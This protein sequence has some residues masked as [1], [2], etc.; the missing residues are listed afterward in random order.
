MKRLISVILTLLMFVSC[1][2]IAEGTDF[3]A[4]DDATL[5]A[6]IN[7]ARNE[8]TKREMVAAEN[9]VLFEQDGVSVY[10]TGKHE[11]W[12]SDSYYLDLEAVLVNDS[13][14]S[15]YL[16][17]DTAYVNGWEVY[18]GG[19][20]D[21]AAGKKQKANID[22]SISEAGITTYE[23]IEEIEVNIWL[24]DSESYEAIAVLEPITVHFNAE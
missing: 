20:T 22:F 5:H 1:F 16:Y 18:A 17:I 8:L 23:E 10:L 9:I 19:I 7:G 15:V 2:A 11:V 3:S 4:M 6:M 14:A 13:A 12:G 21:T 24:C